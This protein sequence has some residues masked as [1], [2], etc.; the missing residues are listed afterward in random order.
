MKLGDFFNSGFVVEGWKRVRTWVNDKPKLIA[1]GYHFN[2][3][4]K[5]LDW[6]VIYIFPYAKS[7]DESAICIELVEGD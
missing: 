4:G 5:Y 1:E 2:D 3:I 7:V 6:E